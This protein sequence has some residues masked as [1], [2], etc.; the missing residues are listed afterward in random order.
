[1]PRVRMVHELERFQE[2]TDPDFLLALQLY[3]RLIPGQIRTRANEICYWL[4]NYGR[5]SP[6]E[7]CVCG[8]YRDK[9]IIGYAQF[10]YFTRERILIFDYILLHEDYREGGGYQIFFSLLQDWVERQNWEIDYIVTEVPYGYGCKNKEEEPPLVRLLIHSGFA[11]ADCLYYQPQLGPDNAESDVKSYLLIRAVEKPS[12]IS[13]KAYL[14]IVSTIYFQ[15]YERWYKPFIEEELDYGQ[16]L[17]GRF[18]EIELAASNQESIVLNGVK[19]SAMREFIQPPMPSARLNNI[20]RSLIAVVS[21]I[22]TCL[23]LLAFQHLFNRDLHTM[24]T[25]AMVSAVVVSLGFALFNPRAERIL[26][27]ILNFVPFLA[28]KDNVGA[29]PPRHRNASKQTIKAGES[30]RK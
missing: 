14:N 27:T 3:K 6:D 20:A 29:K 16:P 12:S 4:E 10:V 22:I 15:H 24:T 13:S 2:A 9:L 28:K 5:N 8:L 26:S 21:V 19:S 11:V 30:G 25:L 18:A 1:M 17:K 7:F 23:L